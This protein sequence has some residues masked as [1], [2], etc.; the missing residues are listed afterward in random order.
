MTQSESRINP[1]DQQRTQIMFV[2][3]VTQSMAAEIAGVKE[4]IREFMAAILERQLSVEVGLTYFRDIEYNQRTGV[5]EFAEG[6][7]TSDAREFIAEMDQLKAK[8]GGGNSY[9][10]SKHGLV[11]A[12]RCFARDVRRFLVLITDQRP[13]PDGQGSDPSS[14]AVAG[15]VQYA[16][17]DE[18]YLVVP[19]KYARQFE[20]IRQP[21]G[22]KVF[23]LS[24]QGRSP[25]AFSSILADIGASIA[26][27]LKRIPQTTPW[28]N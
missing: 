14:K 23:H 1:G 13:Y 16:K 12:C 7:F 20:P 22:A 24:Q 19:E 25:A 18:L 8:G 17:V 27:Y 4:N 26:T 10:S 9:E 2:L 11:V 21:T 28:S 15:A 5:L 3:D 6:P